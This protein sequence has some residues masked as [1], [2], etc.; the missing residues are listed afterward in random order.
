MKPQP[1]A[2][3]SVLGADTTSP[4]PSTVEVPVAPGF[5]QWPVT[6]NPNLAPPVPP[7]I[8][9]VEEDF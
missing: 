8:V 9:P 2:V 5:T 4:S 7:G 3:L 1:R 6:P